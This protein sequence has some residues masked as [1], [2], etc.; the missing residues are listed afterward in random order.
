MHYIFASEISIIIVIFL[1]NPDF[2]C[3]DPKD[4]KNTI[5]LFQVIRIEKLNTEMFREVKINMM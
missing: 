2:G 1:F 4:R 5:S 3:H